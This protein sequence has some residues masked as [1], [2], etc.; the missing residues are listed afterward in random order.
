MNKLKRL[1]N[2]MVATIATFIGTVIMYS[3]RV[4]AQS[5]LG[6]DTDRATRELL[7]P[8]SNMT[9]VILTTVSLIGVIVVIVGVVKW[10]SG[11]KN[12]NDEKVSQGIKTFVIGLVLASITT[13]LNILQIN[14]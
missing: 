8:L 13:V 6:D 5:G 14:Y 7:Q 10:A 3:N 4:L 9:T 2:T 11:T 1:K 12:G